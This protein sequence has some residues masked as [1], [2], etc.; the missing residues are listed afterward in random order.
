MIL[1]LIIVASLMVTGSVAA[2]APTVNSNTISWPDD[3]WYQVQQVTPDGIVEVCQGGQSCAV[4]PGRY[5]VINHSTDERFDD[6]V[7]PQDQGTASSVVVIEDTISWPDNGWYQVLDETNYSEVC[8][9]LRSCAVTPGTYLVINHTTA[10]R[11][12]GIVVSDASNSPA[13]VISVTENVISWPSDG[14]YQ[15]QSAADYT[16][17]CEGGTSCSLPAGRYTVINHTTGLRWEGVM[18]DGP[19][20]STTVE[21]D[22]TVPAYVSDTLQVGVVWGDNTVWANW[23][24][25]ESWLATHDLPMSTENALVI[26]FYDRNR[27]LTLGSYEQDYTTGTGDYEFHTVTADQFDTQRWDDDG[28]GVSNLD[29]LLAGTDPLVVDTTGDFNLADVSGDLLLSSAGYQL[30]R[31]AGV[32]DDMAYIIGQTTTINWPDSDWYQ[33]QIQ[34]LHRITG[35]RTVY[36]SV[37]N[38]GTECKLLPGMHALINHTTGERSNLDLPYISPDDQPHAIPL[39]DSTYTSTHPSYQS[40]T[41]SMKRTQYECELGGSMIQETGTGYGIRLAGATYSGSVAGPTYSNGTMQP[42]R[43]VFDQCYM[44]VRDGLLPSGN[45]LLQGKL[46]TVYMGRLDTVGVAQFDDF[47][48]VGDSGLEYHVQGSV[49]DADGY[50]LPYAH[51]ATVANYEKKLP[52]GQQGEQLTSLQY[53]YGGQRG[54]LLTTNGNVRNEKTANQRVTLNTLA[55]LD[56]LRSNGNY[57]LLRAFS[58]A[59]EM[60]A[61]DGSYLFASANPSQEVGSFGGTFYLDLD[62]TTKNGDQISQ[63]SEL[64]RYSRPEGSCS[65]GRSATTLR[66]GCAIGFRRGNTRGVTVP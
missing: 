22:I 51:T 13:S 5:I 16:T 12:E 36:A 63:T 18:I 26:T 17:V 15:V 23:I 62:Y 3:G 30:N 58:G 65:F 60:L 56:Y 39:P 61:D 14:W 11:F 38:G 9:G 37:C 47:S 40:T 43:Y 44:T 48:I 32:V 53:S 54:F 21:Y 34:G 35:L 64:G 41:V 50:Y 55:P 59:L 49:S 10:E 27:E 31:L 4:L 57:V 42:H 8:S 1:R 28:D 66:M 6:I 20:A 29:E 33:V 19:E 2:A 46:E 24:Q 45:Y 52:D 25:D 7:V